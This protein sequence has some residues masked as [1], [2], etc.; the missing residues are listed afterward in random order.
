MSQMKFEELNLSKELLKAIDD[1]GFEEATPIQAQTIPYIY[2]GKDV[3]GQAQTGTGKTAAFGLPILDMINSRDK[4]QQAIILCPTR[5]LAI[6]VAGEL[7]AL[8][9]YKEGIRILPVYG[10]QPIERQIHALKNGVQIIIGTP[11]RV[12]DHIRRNTL[13]LKNTKDSCAG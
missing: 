11:G 10:G 6:Q 7:K 12:L 2:K 8:S 1:M 5:E 4:S 3:I 9:K 13:K